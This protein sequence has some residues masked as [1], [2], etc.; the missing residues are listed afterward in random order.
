ME[1][2]AHEIFGFPSRRSAT[3]LTFGDGG[4]A[5]VVIAGD[6]RARVVSMDAITNGGVTIVSA[7]FCG[8]ANYFFGQVQLIA[9]NL[10]L[11]CQEGRPAGASLRRSSSSSRRAIRNCPRRGMSAL[12]SLAD[13]Q[14]WVAW[15]NEPLGDKLT[16]VPYGRAGGMAKADVPTTWGDRAVA[17]ARAR[18]LINGH[19]VGIGIQLG[20][21]RADTYLGGIDIDSCLVDGVRATDPKVFG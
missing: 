4:A 21:L 3:E 7:D 5:S 6:K 18:R 16:K 1:D 8:G 2:L 10:C 13:A 14:R 11:D 15:R 20:D 19:G 17:E 9:Q 12:D